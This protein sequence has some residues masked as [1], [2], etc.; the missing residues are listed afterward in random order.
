[1]SYTMEDLRLAAAQAKEEGRVLHVEVRNTRAAG[2]TPIRGMVVGM[3]S[4]LSIQ[5]GPGIGL[6]E[7]LRPEQVSSAWTEA[8]PVIPLASPSTVL[9]PLELRMSGLLG[10]LDVDAAASRDGGMDLPQRER[11]ALLADFAVAAV[12]DAMRLLCSAAEDAAGE[13]G[14]L[15]SEAG[16]P[17]GEPPRPEALR[18][19]AKRMVLYGL[20]QDFD[21]LSRQAAGT[22]SFLTALQAEEHDL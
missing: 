17:E 18:L 5:A 4:K 3:G 21:R 7:D 8:R 19:D 9:G 10:L 20:S 12:A 11:A 16:G 1:M 14:R 2:T 13:A 6:V 22:P 15:C